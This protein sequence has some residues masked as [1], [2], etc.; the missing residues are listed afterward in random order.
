MENDAPSSSGRYLDSRPRQFDVGE[1]SAMPSSPRPEVIPARGDASLDL[2]ELGLDDQLRPMAQNPDEPLIDYDTVH[3]ITGDPRGND[4]N[5]GPHN[6][7]GGSTSRRRAREPEA[8]TPN[9]RQ[10]VEVDSMDVAINDNQGLS[11]SPIR[12]LAPEIQRSSGSLA[13]SKEAAVGSSCSTR[14][15]VYEMLSRPT[16][17]SDLGP[18][19][20]CRA[21]EWIETNIVPLCACVKAALSHPPSTT[22]QA[23]RPALDVRE[24]ESIFADIPAN[25]GTLGYRLL[26]GL[27]LPF[28]R[29]AYKLVAPG[30]QLAHDLVVHVAESA[31]GV[32]K[33]LEAEKEG[34]SLQVTQLETNL[35]SKK[36]ARTEADKEE[37]TKNAVEV[38]TAE[39]RQVALVD[40]KRSEEF[41][42]LLD[43]ATGGAI[44]GN[45]T[46]VANRLLE[47]MASNNY[48][49][50]NNR[51]KT[52]NAAGMYEVEG[53]NML[54]AK[55]DNS[56]NLF[57]KMSNVNSVSTTMPC[58]LCRGAHLTNECINAEQ[59][60]YVSNFSRP[61]NNDPYSNTYN[62]GWRNHPNFS[63][64]NPGQQNVNVNSQI[65]PGFHQKQPQQEIRPSWELA[66]E[67]L[68]NATSER[69]E[70]LETKVDQ[71]AISN[72][73]VE[74]QLGQLANAINSRSQGVLPSKTEVNP[75]QHCNAVTL[76][77]D[78]K[79]YNEDESLMHVTCY[80]SPAVLRAA[81]LYCCYVLLLLAT[82][83]SCYFL[84]F[85]AVVSCCGYHHYHKSS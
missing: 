23:F 41:I 38:A 45:T 7:G 40:F 32:I 65:S 53:I 10:S 51:G 27:Q 5:P 31:G 74:L 55:V 44:M 16:F 58:N 15:R 17:L 6:M 60:Q 25:G 33:G 77:N 57:T 28:D 12:D 19:I 85:C 67:K 42:G 68:A 22:G 29:P 50:S 36:R 35:E 61:P 66:I 80:C 72:R 20:Y 46:E 30:T 26:K 2:E 34:L 24:D 39:A 84:L 11:I 37:E 83:M 8:E 64:R 71:I 18:G 1:G 81:A 48:H 79:D 4:R 76:R 3:G 14:Q 54:N 73:N 52:K 13:R 59:A 70:K 82:A 75:K 21:Q 78:T 63:W 49:W 47:E 43:A 56:V 69:I 9:K 62:P